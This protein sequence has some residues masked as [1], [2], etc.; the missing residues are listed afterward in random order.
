[1]GQRQRRVKQLNFRI[2]LAK[3]LIGEFST[4]ASLG[5][6]AKRRYIQNLSLAPEN[7]GKHFSVKIKGRK[8][9]CVYCKR[10]GRKTSG[11]GPSFRREQTLFSV[12]RVLSFE[13]RRKRAP[14]V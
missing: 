6:S 4:T 9:V 5:H 7:I 8:K 14:F 10:V 13:W 2:N 12:L 3:A 1:M 11:S